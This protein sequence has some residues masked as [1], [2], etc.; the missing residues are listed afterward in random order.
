[1]AEGTDETL[2]PPR[3][4]LRVAG[5][6]PVFFVDDADADGRRSRRGTCTRRPDQPER[7]RVGLTLGLDR[8]DWAAALSCLASAC[9]PT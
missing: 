8:L 4:T 3:G 9:T 5:K 7:V 1:M 6:R 2:T